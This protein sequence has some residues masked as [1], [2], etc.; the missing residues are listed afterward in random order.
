M[1]MDGCI[2]RSSCERLVVSI[3]NMLFGFGVYVP[4]GNA[5][6]NHV[7]NARVVAQP[8]E[9]VVWLNVSVHEALGVNV[10]HPLHHLIG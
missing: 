7:E 10:L 1:G 5:H 6:V 8:H 9:E 4:L 2:P 3:S